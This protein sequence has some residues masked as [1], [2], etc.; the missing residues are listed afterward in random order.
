M[1]DIPDDWDQLQEATPRP[2][3][4]GSFPEQPETPARITLVAAAWADLV[5][6]LAV[7]TASLMA[8]LT[9]G[10]RAT[11]AALPWAVALAVAWWLAAAAV[12]V[13]VRRGTP[14]MLLA[15]VAF[16]RAVPTRRLPS[17]LA[18]ALLLS[19]TFGV[20]ALVGA[21]R[22]PLRAVSSADLCVLPAE[23]H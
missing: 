14:G 2:P 20:P 11:L 5:A 8:L 1:T 17:V 10:H 16:D 4:G 22:S 3:R 9:L 18:V 23:G 19:A 6:V 7:C 15:G 21:E 13:V 12:L